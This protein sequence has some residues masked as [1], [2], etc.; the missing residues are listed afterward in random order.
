MQVGQTGI[1]M[2]DLLGELYL[3]NGVSFHR[4][5]VLGWVV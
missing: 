4:F 5:C 1:E 2:M 3:K